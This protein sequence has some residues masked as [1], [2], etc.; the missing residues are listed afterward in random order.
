MHSRLY[1]FVQLALF[2]GNALAAS[3]V[4]PT[5]TLDDAT[6]IGYTNNSVTSFMGIPFAEPPCVLSPI[7]LLVP[8][9]H[10]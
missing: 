7:L 8:L 1:M 5:A 10:I 6:V 3:A 4:A 2:L 9:A